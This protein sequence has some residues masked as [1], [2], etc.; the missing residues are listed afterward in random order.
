MDQRDSVELRRRNSVIQRVAAERS[1][2]RTRE[3]RERAGGM[4]ME[5]ERERVVPQQRMDGRGGAVAGR[6]GAVAGEQRAAKSEEET[7]AAIAARN[8][9]A[10]Q[11]HECRRL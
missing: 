8:A 10:K 2:R 3:E 11:E 7:I 4:R 1:G 6:R 9:A 5:R